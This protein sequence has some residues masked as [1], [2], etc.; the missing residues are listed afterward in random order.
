MNKL[1]LTLK[2]WRQ[3]SSKDKGQFETHKLKDL[4]TG[5][6]DNQYISNIFWEKIKTNNNIDN[7]VPIFSERSFLI[8]S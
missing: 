1:N 4:E 6:Y 5:Q 8:T 3:S 7:Q 2:V